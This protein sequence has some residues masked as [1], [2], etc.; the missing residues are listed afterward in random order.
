MCTSNNF[1]KG[2]QLRVFKHLITACRTQI[3]ALKTINFNAF[4][5]LYYYPPTQKKI[6]H[7]QPQLINRELTSG[8]EF[9]EGIHDGEEAVCGQGGQGKNGYPDG[10][11]LGGFTQL[12]D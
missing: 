11:V 2:Y 5:T 6:F 7:P 9:L 10:N 4:C 8:V 1:L 12:A 3:F